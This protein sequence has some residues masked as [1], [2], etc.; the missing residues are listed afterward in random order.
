MGTAAVSR[1]E[2]LP[3]HVLV[4]L[5]GYPPDGKRPPEVHAAYRPDTPL[6]ELEQAGRWAMRQADR[7]VNRHGGG[8]HVEGR[9]WTWHNPT[10]IH[11]LAGH[12]DEIMHV[13]LPRF[14]PIDP[15]SL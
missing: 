2:R 6:H 3:A 12:R 9:L 11:V 8:D 1:W 15:G 5:H 4:V 14:D 10:A 7:Y 13:T